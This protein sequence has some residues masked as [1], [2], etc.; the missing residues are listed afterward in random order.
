MDLENE[1]TEDLFNSRPGDL[2]F[3]EAS[4]LLLM[5]SQVWEILLSDNLQQIAASLSLIKHFFNNLSTWLPIYRSPLLYILTC[6]HT[7][8]QLAS[9]KTGI[10]IPSRSIHAVHPALS[11]SA[12]TNADDPGTL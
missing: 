1:P 10:E 4:E 6:P 8:S 3:Y 5:D 12:K 7:G 2:S 9:T 11:G